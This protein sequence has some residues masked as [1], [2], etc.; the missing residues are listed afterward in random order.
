MTY[1]NDHTAQAVHAIRLVRTVARQ[2]LTAE[3]FLM[4]GSMRPPSSAG[5]HG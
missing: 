4:R 3:I 2:M 1:L 5:G